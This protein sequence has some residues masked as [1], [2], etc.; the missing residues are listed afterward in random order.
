[1]H[2]VAVPLDEHQVLHANAAELADAPDIVAAQVDQHDVL[3]DLLLVGAQ[4]GLHRAVFHLIRAARPRPGDGPILH[5]PPMHAH[6]QLRRGADDVRCRL[7][8]DCLAASSMPNR[9]K[10]M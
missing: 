6:Q 5:R 1:M 2:H 7:G 9:R 8:F 4:I 3:G 10:Y